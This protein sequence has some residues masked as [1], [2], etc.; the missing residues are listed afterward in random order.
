[1]SLVLT[2]VVTNS[3][4]EEYKGEA[5]MHFFFLGRTGS[6]KLQVT[7]HSPNIKPEK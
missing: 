4:R 2:E 1:M 7:T 6:V 5:S 3:V